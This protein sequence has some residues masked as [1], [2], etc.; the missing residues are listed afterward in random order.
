MTEQYRVWNAVNPPSQMDFY[1][2]EGP[3]EGE[4]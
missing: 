1:P 4:G 3:E 2:V